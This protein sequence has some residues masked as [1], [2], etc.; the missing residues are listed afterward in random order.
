MELEIL[1]KGT[2]SIPEKSLEKVYKDLYKEKTDLNLIFI[3]DEYSQKLNKKYR[4]KNYP[5]NVLSFYTP[6]EDVSGVSEIY[7][8]KDFLLKEK[9]KDT[10]EDEILFLFIHSVLH[11]LGHEHGEKMDELEEKYFNLYK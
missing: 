9:I 3:D 2:L 4:N 6:S 1:N 5:T 8:N 7:I 10:I 11:L